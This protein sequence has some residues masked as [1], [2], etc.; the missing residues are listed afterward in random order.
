MDAD[1]VP[2]I[3]RKYSTELYENYW[4]E[5]VIDSSQWIS[6]MLDKNITFV[7]L[8]L[9]ESNYDLY[10]IFKMAHARVWFTGRPGVGKKHLLIH[11]LSK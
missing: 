3:V 9:K 2:A 6:N 7:D 5:S 10:V 1:Y 11:Y 8:E 4:K